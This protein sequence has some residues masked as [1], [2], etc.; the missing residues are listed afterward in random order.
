MQLQP[1]VQLFKCSLPPIWAARFNT[2]WPRKT[3]GWPLASW[4]IVDHPTQLICICICIYLY[5][6]IQ[7]HMGGRGHLERLI[8]VHLG[9]MSRMTKHISSS[10]GS[11]RSWAHLH[12]IAPPFQL[13]CKHMTTTFQASRSRCRGHT[14]GA[15]YRASRK[16]D[17]PSCVDPQ[18]LL[19]SR[20]TLQKADKMQPGSSDI[21]HLTHFN[22]NNMPFH[23]WAPTP[24]PFFKHFVPNV[25]VFQL[26]LLLFQLVLQPYCPRKL[27]A[28]SVTWGVASHLMKGKGAGAS[29]APGQTKE[30]FSTN[31]KSKQPS[32]RNM[33]PEKTPRCILPCI[34]RMVQ[35]TPSQ[36]PQPL[37]LKSVGE[38]E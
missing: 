17:P 34:K 2:F 23:L 24:L 3:H 16:M 1:L 11:L 8:L 18:S 33:L 22:C 21:W 25:Q 30:E 14:E 35:C 5:K 7:R 12:F 6:Q 15:K 36:V 10:G 19:A 27:L 26:F 32:P 37:L 28:C 13:P 29:E 9:K 4:E 31:D 38:P 20:M